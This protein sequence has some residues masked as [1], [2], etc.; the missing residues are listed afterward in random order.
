MNYITTNIVIGVSIWIDDEK[1]MPM[2]SVIFPLI[3][4]LLMLMVISL[5]I[6]N[7]NVVNFIVVVFGLIIMSV[8]STYI[9]S[10]LLNKLSYK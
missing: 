1:L 3:F 6:N 10:I 4:I 5:F 2:L 7:V 8:L 9:S